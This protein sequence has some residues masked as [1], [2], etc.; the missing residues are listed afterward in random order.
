M[1][2]KKRTSFASRAARSAAVGSTRDP[3]A[4]VV[5]VVVVVVVTVV[6]VTGV[7]LRLAVVEGAVPTGTTCDPTGRKSRSTRLNQSQPLPAPPPV[8]SGAP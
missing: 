4:T 7:A 2:L 6:T 5:V 1:R 8:Q 3:S